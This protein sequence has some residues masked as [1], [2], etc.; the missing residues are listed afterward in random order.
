MPVQPTWIRRK[1][2]S[3]KPRRRFS[4]SVWNILP[5]RIIK[6]WYWILSGTNCKSWRNWRGRDL[7]KN[8]WTVS[9]WCFSTFLTL[10]NNLHLRLCMIW[11]M[12]RK[13]YVWNKPWRCFRGPFHTSGTY[14]LIVAFGGQ[15]EDM[16]IL[17]CNCR[18]SGWEQFLQNF[19]RSTSAYKSYIYIFFLS[20]QKL[21]KNC[22]HCQIANP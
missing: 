2:K 6:L 15:L 16:Y 17:V 11:L 7:K 3:I 13:E 18:F 8:S 12:F 22:S 19:C 1:K 21:C 4:V 14:P 9:I 20:L 10:Y 5:T